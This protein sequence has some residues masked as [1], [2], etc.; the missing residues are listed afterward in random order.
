MSDLIYEKNDNTYGNQQLLDV[1][2]DGSCVKKMKKNMLDSGKWSEPALNKVFS[3]AYNA[4]SQFP[5]GEYTRKTLC[6]GKVQS[7]KTAFFSIKKLMKS[8]K[9]R[10]R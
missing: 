8:R 5:D 2:V 9:S 1:V 7:G 3:T 6:L 10:R 4:V